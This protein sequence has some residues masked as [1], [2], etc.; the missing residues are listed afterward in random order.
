VSEGQ[1]RNVKVAEVPI[2]RATFIEKYHVGLE[3]M[4]IS[5]N[6]FEFFKITRT[7]KENATNLFQ[8]PPGR[9]V[10][11]IKALNNGQQVVG[12]FWAASVTHGSIF[13]TKEDLPYTLAK[14]VI[15]F[16]CTSYPNSSAT[17]PDFW[18]E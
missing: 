13:I 2:T 15:P 3:Q 5:K 14:D 17:K 10:G 9:H 8:P 16:P 7:Q 1:F 6:A 18:D 12:L 11:N 4:A